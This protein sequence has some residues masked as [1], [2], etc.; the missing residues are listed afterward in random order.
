MKLRTAIILSI[1]SFVLGFALINVLLMYCFFITL[2]TM[3][4]AFAAVCAAVPILW[5]LI[6]REIEK[7]RIK[8]E[9]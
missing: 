6:G 8:T 4:F 9:M 7:E 2:M 5:Y 1:L 3:V